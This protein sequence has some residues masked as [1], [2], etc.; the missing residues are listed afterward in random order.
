[1]RALSVLCILLTL[2]AASGVRA[3]VPA[4]P[5][6]L[7]T[8]G[9]QI[10]DASGKP[11]RI[12]G[13]NWYGMETSQ[14]VPAGLNFQRYS[15]IMD[16]VRLLGFNTIRLPLSN[17]LI[18][19]NPRVTS[20]VAAN[21]ELRGRRAL[22][23]LDALVVYAG[24]IGL[25]IVLDDHR[26]R[27]ARPEQVN[28]LDEPLWY[29]QG[30]P[31]LAWIRDWETL[32][33]RYAGN[34][35][36]V[37][38]DL[39]NEPHTA[40]PGPWNLH[41]YLTRGA[42]WG[43]YRGAATAARDW[44]A[45]AE[46]AGNAVLRIDPHLLVIVEGIQLYPEAGA[47][48]GVDVSWWSGILSPVKQYPVTLRVPHQ[49]VYSVHDWGPTKAPMPWFKHGTY[50]ELR[51]AWMKR[52]AFLLQK[53]HAAYAAPVLLGEF[54]TCTDRAE[55][56]TPSAPQDRWFT[57]LLRFLRANPA[58]SWSFF[59]LDGTNANDC[60]ADNGLLNGAWNDVA[61]WSL[62]QELRSAG[63]ATVPGVQ[64]GKADPLIP[65]TTTLRKPR[66]PHSRLCLIP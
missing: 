4:Q 17:E 64:A 55:C 59:A 33:R 60:W 63:A 29:T 57:S 40:G 47:A 49:L 26:S 22:D 56:T 35:T 15:T 13:I 52:W 36:V 62:E 54:G 25:R 39:R 12:V 7:R 46:R 10:V 3:S 32:A 66:D 45:A 14:W 38:F 41:A 9:V 34:P 8:S 6:Y 2:G 43:P 16:E 37:G 61:S 65:G 48:N 23:V 31:E 51:Q 21:P 1:M 30:Y 11:F 50:A 53:P 24:R 18:E 27:A 28:N 58:L 5:G 44:R 19:R 42:T 20:G